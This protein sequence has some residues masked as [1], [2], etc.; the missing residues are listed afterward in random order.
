M[1]NYTFKET[2]N[3]F[4][5][6]LGSIPPEEDVEN[7]SVELELNGSLMVLE[8]GQEEGSLK[9]CMDL[10]MFLVPPNQAELNKLASGNFLGIQTQGGSL[11]LDEEGLLLTLQAITSSETSPQQNW[12]CLQR[13]VS[14][15]YFWSEELDKKE[16]FSLLAQLDKLEEPPLQGQG[17]TLKV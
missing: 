16:N 14:A 17:K 4:A 6:K 15:A 11:C 12:D 9:I 10:G 2:I 1:K 13:F 5:E 7:K 8:Q 3:Y